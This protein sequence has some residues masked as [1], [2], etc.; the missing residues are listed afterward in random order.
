MPAIKAGIPHQGNLP[1]T[2]Q[3]R[4]K[5]VWG[6][7]ALLAVIAVTIIAYLLDARAVSTRTT[8]LLLVQPLSIVALILAA[9]V[10][11][12]VF[13]KEGSDEANELEGETRGDLGRCFALIGALGFL[14][15][16]LETIGFD[17]ATFVF[18]VFAMA[19]CGERRWL[20][21]LIF[22]AV[23]T[24]LLIYGYGTITPFPF[25]LTVL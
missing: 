21:N 4:R 11:P 23:F 8:N 7:L 25:P 24:V 14:A 15:F 17:I 22:S 5:M 1:M 3:P 13:V 10:L 2:T 16:S 19:I 20:V 9:I 6:H 18:M 12:G